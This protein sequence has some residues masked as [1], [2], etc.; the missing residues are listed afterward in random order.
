MKFKFRIILLLLFVVTG[1]VINSCKKENQNNLQSLLTTGQ[2]QLASI[3]VTHYIGGTQTGLVLA[4]D[5]NCSLKQF[6]KFNADFTCSYTNFDCL[7]STMATGHWSLTQ[8]QLFLNSDIVCKQTVASR[9]S[10]AAG[11]D[12]TNLTSPTGIVSIKPFATARV[13]NLGI[14]SLVLE[15]GDLQTF[16]QPNQKRTVVQYGFI[17][18]NTQ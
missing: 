16:Y 12:T 10:T 18:Q 4:I 3:Q 2:W 14:N 8:N 7:D 5:S 1:L 17:R 13:M 15:T 11:S 9:D 6:F